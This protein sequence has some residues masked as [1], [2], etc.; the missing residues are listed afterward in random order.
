MTDK[1]L[2]DPIPL[3]TP[4]V[5]GEQTLDALQLRRPDAG[6]LRGLSLARL[7]NGDV[8][9]TLQLLPRITMPP[10][11][12]IEAGKLDPADLYELTDKVTDFFLTR[13]R[14]ESLPTI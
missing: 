2:T 6:E 4:I 3:E 13:R 1:S 9:E 14:R 5:R 10:I 8:T 7:A 12:A 11:T